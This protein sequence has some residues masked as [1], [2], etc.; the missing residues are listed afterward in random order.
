[1]PVLDP[2]QRGS[3]SIPVR[4]EEVTQDGQLVLEFLPQVFG[5]VVWQGL[6][7]SQPEW[8]ALYRAGIIPIL[9]RVVIEAGDGPI[10]PITPATARGAYGLARAYAPTGETERM[11]LCMWGEVEAPRSRLH[12]PKPDGVGQPVVAGRVFA[13]HVFTR[14]FAGAGERR[15]V[16]L[17]PGM[18]SVPDAA[19]RERAVGELLA[20]PPGAI[21]LDADLA[22]D[23]STLVVGLDHTDS[24][25]H[26]N[27]L[28]YP[29]LFVEA[30]LRRAARHGRPLRVVAKRMEIAY[31]RPSFVGETLRAHVAAW[32]LGERTHVAG[33]LVDDASA[34]GESPLARPRCAFRLE[35]GA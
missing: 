29:R 20:A 8:Q 13:E 28:A 24:N 18:P 23:P 6:L 15:V 34:P 26:V 25:Q 4:Y 16:A 19:H 5:L 32:A 27:S 2:S 22:P 33:V 12:G 3:S 9:R 11:F 17:D 14:P 7:D 30:A 21:A 10:S 1:M 35:L 31:L